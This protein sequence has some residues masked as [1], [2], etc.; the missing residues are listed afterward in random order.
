MTAA[1]ASENV[2]AEQP[3]L[4]RLR[5]EHGWSYMHGSELVPNAAGAERTL[6]SDVVLLGRLRQALA[7]IN[8]HLPA[9]A[10]DWASGIALTTTSPSVIEDHR[11]FH[12]LLLSGVPVSY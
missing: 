10:V 4:A 2:L 6:W 8:P 1:A 7:R 11:G 5:E 12:D 9:D 3:A